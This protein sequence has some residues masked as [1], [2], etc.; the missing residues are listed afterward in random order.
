MQWDKHAMVWNWNWILDSC[1]M[2]LEWAFY[3]DFIGVNLSLLSTPI[4]FQELKQKSEILDQKL[5]TLQGQML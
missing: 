2:K 3:L 4:P 1:L 5:S